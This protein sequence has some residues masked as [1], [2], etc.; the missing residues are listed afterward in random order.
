MLEALS[1]SSTTGIQA[2]AN[3]ETPVAP[4]EVRLKAREQFAL[5]DE[6]QLGKSLTNKL[7]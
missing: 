6:A 7:I 4:D 2:S 3:K 1:V 5:P